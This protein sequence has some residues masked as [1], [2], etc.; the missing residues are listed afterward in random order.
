MLRR[1]PVPTAGWAGAATRWLT[2]PARRRVWQLVGPPDEVTVAPAPVP[3]ALL[4]VPL[5]SLLSLA[6]AVVAL[7]T[8]DNDTI[9]GMFGGIALA[10][11]GT[12]F[13]L[14]LGTLALRQWLAHRVVPASVHGPVRDTAQHTG[15]P[16]NEPQAPSEAGAVAADA[17][18]PANRVRYP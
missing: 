16:S 12:G 8:S 13:L 18:E 2:E 17:P 6:T 15:P 9:V 11:A 10:L 3:P 7:L 4:L 5:L 1:Q 14:T